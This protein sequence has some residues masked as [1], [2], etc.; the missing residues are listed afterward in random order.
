MEFLSRSFSEK[1]R[2]FLRKSFLGFFLGIPVLRSTI[3]SSKGNQ[4]EV[5]KHWYLTANGQLVRVEDEASVKKNR[6]LSS[7]KIGRWLPR[8]KKKLESL[9]T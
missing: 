4:D 7:S 3:R 6:R 1:R 5:I 9:K 2:S 8:R